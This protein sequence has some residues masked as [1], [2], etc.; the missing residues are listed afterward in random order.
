M[1]NINNDKISFYQLLLKEKS[2]LTSNYM[3]YPYFTPIIIVLNKSIQNDRFQT[4]DLTIINKNFNHWTNNILILN[5]A[6]T[7]KCK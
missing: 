3:L 7:S 2:S 4:H 5:F 1:I 6:Y